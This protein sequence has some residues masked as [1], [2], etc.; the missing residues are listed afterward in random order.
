MEKLHPLLVD[1]VINTLRAILIEGRYADKAIEYTLKNNKKWGSRDR[2][3]VSS[4]VYNIIRYLPFYE[5]IG[6]LQGINNV[7]LRVE[8]LFAAYFWQQWKELPAYPSNTGLNSDQ[9]K[10]SLAATKGNTRL[11]ESYPEW[12]WE[13]LKSDYP[14]DYLEL[15]HKLNQEA[16]VVIRCNT[17]KTDAQTLKAQ[18]SAEGFEMIVPGEGDALQLKRRGSLFRSMAF[19]KGLFEVQDYASQQVAPFCEVKSGELVVD[20]CAG[21]GGKTLHLAA[22]MQNKGRVIAMDVEE[23]KLEELKK[24][25]RR[26]GAGNI[27]IRA[28]TSTKVVKRM[29]AKADCVLIDAPCSG[30]G[31]FRRNPDAKWKLKPERLEE[32][33]QLQQDIL[34]RNAVMVRP[35]GRLIYATCSVFRVENERQIAIFLEKNPDFTLIK[36]RTLTPHQF[37]YDGFYMALLQKQEIK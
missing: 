27:E 10:A 4:S 23:Y 17:L 3:F 5:H 31:T 20:A 36:E 32:L 15:M 29:A 22:M 21:A 37:G 6:N 30:S 28:L 35:G 33:V 9:L 26:A 7:Q 12:I 16:P 1:G 14:D 18:L 11:L 2:A 24:R 19:K 13:M 34:A 25:M 8:R